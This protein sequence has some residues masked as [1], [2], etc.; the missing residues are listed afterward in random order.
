MLAVLP[1]FIEAGKSYG[2]ALQKAATRSARDEGLQEFYEELYFETYELRKHIENLVLELPGLSDERKQEVVDS[3]DLDDWDQ[4]GD[5]AAALEDFLSPDDHAAFHMVMEKVLDLLA[6]LV[7]DETVHL[8]KSDKVC[9]GL[10]CGMVWC[11]EEGKRMRV[12][13][14]VPKLAPAICFHRR[15]HLTSL[16][17]LPRLHL[18]R[19]TPLSL[20]K[21][22]KIWEHYSIAPRDPVTAGQN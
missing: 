7:K 17:C 6:R 11:Q 3:R 8:S 9:M 16:S 18:C 19:P 14:P 20:R 12:Q 4:A 21:R 1:F 5:V 10:L 2:D 15:W 13:S 22:K